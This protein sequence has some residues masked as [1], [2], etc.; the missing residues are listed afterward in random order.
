MSDMTNTVPCLRL[1]ASSGNREADDPD[2]FY[3]G[4]YESEDIEADISEAVLMLVDGMD[5][6]I[7]PITITFKVAMLTDKQA[8]DLH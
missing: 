7:E 5:E 1:L 6:E 3:V 2:W 8:E 4:D